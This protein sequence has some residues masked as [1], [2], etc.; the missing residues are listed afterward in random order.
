MTRA[1]CDNVNCV[2]SH[3][4][5]LLDWGGFV[6]A[7]LPRFYM[8]RKERSRP[9]GSRVLGCTLVFTMILASSVSALAPEPVTVFDLNPS[10]V[11][12]LDKLSPPLTEG[13]RAI[14]A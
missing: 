10:L 5:N 9:T 3:C 2:S 8:E 11:V 1:K 6:T 4:G 12:Q 14:L 13:L 7:L